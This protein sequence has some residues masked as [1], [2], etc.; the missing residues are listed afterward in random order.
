MARMALFE[1]GESGRL[2]ELADFDAAREVVGGYL[3][4][5][6]LGD[7]GLLVLCDEDGLPKGLPL[8][9]RIAARGPDIDVKKFD[10]VVGLGGAQ[11]LEPGVPGYHD[12]VGRFLVCR[13]TPDAFESLTDEDAR[14]LGVAA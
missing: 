9:R 10:L 6:R 1:V 14:R 5:V 7:D 2:V 13:G 8:N 4:V 12:I 3:Q 11:L